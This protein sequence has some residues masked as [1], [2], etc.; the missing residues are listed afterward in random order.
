MAT[1]RVTGKAVETA[2]ETHGAGPLLVLCHGGAAG[3][4]SFDNF[5]PLLIGSFTVALYDQRDTGE[6][7]N[8]PEPY[9]MADLGRDLGELIDDL[10]TLPA[11]FFGT[12]FGGAVALNGVIERPDAVRAVVIGSSWPGGVFPVSADYLAALR[13]RSNEAGQRVARL[14]YFSAEFAER[15]RDGALCL[16]SGVTVERS[17]A[18]Q[19]RRI[20][21]A[22]S[23]D[24]CDRLSNVRA[25]VLVAAGAD[26]RIIEPRVSREMAGR[27]PDARFVIWPGIGH[28][29][30][31][32]DPRT[33]ASTLIQ[34][35]L[36]AETAVQ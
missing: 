32:E 36:E 9:D 12:S 8:G 35:F 3:R 23:H 17:P 7:A 4:R 25:P 18:A 30:T 28:A 31:L 20:A 16:L 5:W 21:A 33:V 29:T 27:I 15:D 22:R 24:V 14:M 10:G 2:Y 26:D 6:T 13:D 11:F 34:F 1:A 19:A